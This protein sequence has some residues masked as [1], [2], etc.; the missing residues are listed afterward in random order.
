MNDVLEQ[1][2]VYSV[3]RATPPSIGFA[4]L[5]SLAGGSGKAIPFS[6]LLV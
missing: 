5:S 2:N 6:S 3:Y 1:K 4:Q